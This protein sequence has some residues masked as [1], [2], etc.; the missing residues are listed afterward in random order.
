MIEGIGGET[1]RCSFPAAWAAH[2]LLDR[3]AGGVGL[4]RGR[5]DLSHLLVGEALD[6]WR[7]EAIEPGS[8]CSCAEM[9][10]PA[11]TWLEMSVGQDDD[12]LI[13]YSQGAI[14]QVDYG[15]KML[16]RVPWTPQHAGSQRYEMTHAGTSKTARVAENSQQAGRFRRWWQVLWQVLGSNQRRLSRRFYSPCAP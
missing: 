5:R 7:V 13:T 10:L 6:F 3:L 11:L 1:E 8:S 12:G 4:R 2:G 16:L 9:K 14:L 15:R